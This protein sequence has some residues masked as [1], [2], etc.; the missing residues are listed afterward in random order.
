MPDA[1]YW[2][3][4]MMLVVNFVAMYVLMYAM[5]DVWGNVY[6]NINQVYMAGLMTAPMMVLEILFMRGMYQ[7]RRLNMLIMAGGMVAVVL[8]FFA[9]RAQIAVGDEEFLRSMIPHHAGAVLMCGEATLA[10]PEIKA[11]C[12]GILAGQQAEIEWMRTKLDTLEAN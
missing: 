12:D 8:L 7:N 1:H 10:D 5:V 6:S 2:H 9:I 11:L 3:F 4:G